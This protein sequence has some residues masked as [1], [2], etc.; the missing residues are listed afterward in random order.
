MKRRTFFRPVHTIVIKPVHI[1]K[2]LSLKSCKYM[3]VSYPASRAMLITEYI[4]YRGVSTEKKQEKCEVFLSGSYAF[5]MLHTHAQFMWKI[6]SYTVQD[7]C[8]YQQRTWRPDQDNSLFVRWE[9]LLLVIILYMYTWKH[10]FG[11]F[12]WN[13]AKPQ[14]YKNKSRGIW[15]KQRNDYYCIILFLNCSFQIASHI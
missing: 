13:I 12:R 14:K 8:R 15:K 7:C 9:T 2:S 11:A 1:I 10:V 5:N 4:T 6:F 3:D